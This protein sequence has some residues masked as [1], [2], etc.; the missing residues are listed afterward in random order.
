[1]LQLIHHPY[2]SRCQK[3]VYGHLT[4]IAT[5]NKFD[6][7][8]GTPMISI[9]VN[10]DTFSQQFLLFLVIELSSN[11]MI[12]YNDFLRITFRIHRLKFKIH[13]PNLIHFSLSQLILETYKLII[14]L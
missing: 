2:K 7:L 5:I 12:R 4:R 6:C 11:K 3:W 8:I 13:Y 1:M 9:K 14:F 10:R